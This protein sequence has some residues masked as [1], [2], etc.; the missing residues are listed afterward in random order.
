MQRPS[1]AE[2]DAT[3]ANS[4]PILWIKGRAQAAPVASQVPDRVDQ[5]YPDFRAKAFRHR[6]AS[7]VGQT[8]HQMKSLYEF[9]SHFLIR[10]FNP[11]MYSEFHSLALEDADF[12]ETN[13]GLSNLIKFYGVTLNSNDR[14]IHETVARH[15]IELVK[16]E[17]GK[18]DRPASAQLQA[19]WKNGSIDLKS[20]K[21]IDK[22]IDAQLK[23]ELE[24]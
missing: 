10:N 19:A 15:Y 7:H 17:S 12:R 18:E 5:L 2:G 14:T 13:V 11:K 9:W 1:T 20:R 23:E 24:R 4:P 22:L 3:S 21:I 6:D 8:D 16:R